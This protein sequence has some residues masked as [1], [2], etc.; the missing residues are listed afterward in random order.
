MHHWWHDEVVDGHKLPLMLCFVAFVVT[1][2]V[3]RT[4]TR[5]IR[6][7]RGPFHDNVSSGGT[8]VHHAVPGIVVLCVGAFVAVGSATDGVWR[9]VAGIL[10]GVGVSLVL[11]EF[12]LILRLQDVYWSGEGRL[13]VNIVSLTA[14][15]LGLSLVGLSPVGTESPGGGEL[16]ARIGLSAALVVHGC[17]V[18]CALAKGK[19]RA[20]L[21]GLFMPPVALGGAIRIARPGSRWARRWYGPKEE[22]RATRRAAEFDERWEPVVRRWDNLVGG[23][24]TPG[25]PA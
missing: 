8:H 14:A 22:A 4:V 20:A 5:M 9:P 13:S 3:T 10:V 25:S 17:V 15:C 16:V 21:F 2:V 6:S 1:F 23:A 12:A 18:V 19:Y 7:G 11:D 24:P